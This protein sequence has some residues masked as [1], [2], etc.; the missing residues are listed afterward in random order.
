MS[1]PTIIRAIAFL[2]Q[3]GELLEQKNAA[4][5]DAA[6]NPLRC[7][8]KLSPEEGIRL[9]IDDKLSRL[10]RGDGSGL[11][12]FVAGGNTRVGK[13]QVDGSLPNRCD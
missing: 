2:H 11:P 9:R 4:Y 8:S 3:V 1:S 13:T 10:A 12:G 7:F 5:G 6:A